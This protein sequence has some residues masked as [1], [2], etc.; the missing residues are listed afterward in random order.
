M[1]QLQRFNSTARTSGLLPASDAKA[2]YVSFSETAGSALGQALDGAL[3]GASSKTIKDDEND[4]PCIRAKREYIDILDP[5]KGEFKCVADGPG[6][7]PLV[8]EV[9]SAGPHIKGGAF[10]DVRSREIG[11][12]DAQ[13]RKRAMLEDIDQ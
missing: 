12:Q 13:R 4:P 7:D 3:I 2:S 11:N 1:D 8:I 6:D 9:S 5:V 10:G